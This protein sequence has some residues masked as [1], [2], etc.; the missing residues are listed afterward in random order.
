MLTTTRALGGAEGALFARAAS[1]HCLLTNARCDW[2]TRS[3]S[4]VA[5]WPPPDG[6][7]LLPPLGDSGPPSRPP[8]PVRLVLS[9]AAGAAGSDGF[10]PFDP[11]EGFDETSALTSMG[12]MVVTP[13]VSAGGGAGGGSMT[14]TICTAGC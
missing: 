11:P 12:P 13:S 6:F 2:T 1:Q 14:D 3:T 4:A 8:R 5:S 7:G 9:G 10:A